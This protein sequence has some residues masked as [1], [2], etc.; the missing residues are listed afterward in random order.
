LYNKT[1]QMEKNIIKSVPNSFLLMGNAHHN[2]SQNEI[3]IEYRT[4]GEVMEHFPK[5]SKHQAYLYMEN[6]QKELLNQL[7]YGTK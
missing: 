1:I 6:R 7:L 3:R 4:L 5:N 2:D